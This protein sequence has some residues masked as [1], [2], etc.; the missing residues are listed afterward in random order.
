M[1]LKIYFLLHIIIL[2]W[3]NKTYSQK[4]ILN[5][6]KSKIFNKEEYHPKIKTSG[7]KVNDNLYLKDRGWELDKKD[8][9]YYINLVTFSKEDNFSEKVLSR[10]SSLSDYYSHS[11]LLFENINFKQKVFI[12]KIEGEFFS[13]LLIYS[14][15]NNISL[16]GEITIGNFCEPNCDVFNIDDNDIVVKGNNTSVEITFKGKTFYTTPEIIQSKDG[17][18]IIADDLTLSY[19]IKDLN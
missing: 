18:R 3:S 9:F 13:R 15:N 7:F 2:I 6:Y 5:D 14:I 10:V 12:W 8:N 1:K 19:F 11:Y 4:N 16:L 17:G